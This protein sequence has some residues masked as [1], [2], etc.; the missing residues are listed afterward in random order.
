MFK[1]VKINISILRRNVKDAKIE[2]LELK[3]DRL[4]MC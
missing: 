3:N 4:K 2:L 1:K